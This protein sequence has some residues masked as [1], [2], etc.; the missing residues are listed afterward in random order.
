MQV[1][2]QPDGSVEK[3]ARA[4]GALL[5]IAYPACVYFA[6]GR[7]D[8]RPLSLALAAVVVGSFVLRI[9]GKKRQHALA[10]A[11]I[12][13]SVGAL[14]LLGALCDDRRFV[15][16]LP[17]LT[18]LVLLAQFASSLRGVPVAERFAR[19]QEDDL[20]PAQIAYCRTV[21]IMWCVFF[22]F[23]GSMTAALA[24]AAPVRVW[25]A[26]S[27]GVSYLL[28]GLVVAVEYTVRTL[29]FGATGDGL[30]GRI[31]RAVANRV[32][33][34]GGEVRRFE[35]RPREGRPGSY[36]VHVPANLS[37]FR[38]HFDG[39]AI[40]PGV[41]QVEVLVARQVAITWPELARIRRVTRLRFRRP[42][43]P[44]DDLVLEIKRS[45][46]ERVDFDVRC[47]AEACSS[48][49]LHFEV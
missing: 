18:N 3:A 41:V 20:S 8:V 13:L 43:R 15:L 26:Y 33:S 28:V 23:N 5:L 46:R 16:A 36:D 14:L 39:H 32:R 37:Y 30:L 48:G 7:F 38:G 25:A 4:L 19:A 29:R 45:E 2:G 12:P 40:L 27:G 9:Q 44:G 24:L 6:L 11:R 34:P 31:A 21:T 22:V 49:T 47:G 1:D 17:V 42:I 35:L 10:A